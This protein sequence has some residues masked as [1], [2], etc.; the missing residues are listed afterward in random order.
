MNLE[1]AILGVLVETRRL[2]TRG[3]LAQVDA[4]LRVRRDPGAIGAAVNA[5]LARGLVAEPRGK[6]QGVELTDAGEQAAAAHRP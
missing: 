3:E 6:G 5:L 2:I 1:S 4:V